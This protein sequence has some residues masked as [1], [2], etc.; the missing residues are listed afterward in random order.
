[1]AEVRCA[2][3]GAPVEDAT[4]QLYCVH[5]R[6]RIVH[7]VADLDAYRTA[8]E[9]FDRVTVEP[10]YATAL[11]HTPV[12]PAGRELG[13]PLGN[14]AGGVLVLAALLA[15]MLTDGD[16]EALLALVA[17]GAVW[18]WFAL[19]AVVIAVRR[20][21]A[22]TERLVAI[23]AADHYAATFAQ[24]DPVGVCNHRVVLRDR[25]GATRAVYA[26]GA[27]MGDVA[28]GDI[29]LAY[30]RRDRLVDYRW[31]DVMAPPLEPGEVPRAAGCPSCGAH[32]QFGP[33]GERCAFCDEPL[34]RPDLGEFGARFRAAAASPEAA[35]ACDRRIA[36]GVPS[37]LPPLALTAGGALLARGA[38]AV[39]DAFVAAIDYSSWFLLLPIAAVM[40]LVAGG[41][42]LWRR[43]APHRAGRRNELV[44]IVR[45]RSE[46]V[47][48]G[49]HP[50]W[51]YFVTVAAP[52]G[53][54]RELRVLRST[55]ARVGRGQ[56]GVA[57]L[58][59]DWLAGFTALGVASAST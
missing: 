8:P 57:H 42:W 40:P 10:G 33:I 12:L 36:G 32:Q 53:A 30:L 25:A 31:F 50:S 41:I 13:S 19:R 38:F 6:A 15:L 45:T 9:R 1:M 34:P 11:H 51:H 44:V 18:L 28:V 22:P 59:G 5:C 27:L 16:R 39:R 17:V 49:E 20:V 43:S 46:E 4:A 3:C 56:L 58:R 21:R 35:V 54:R 29:G 14:L 52:N 48:R 47:R 24:R 26:P 37:L 23:V 7:G 55:A 2:R